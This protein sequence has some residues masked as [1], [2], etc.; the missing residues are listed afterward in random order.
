M[1]RGPSTR[2][3]PAPWVHILI[4]ADTFHTLASH[5]IPAGCIIASRNTAR[6]LDVRTK[7]GVSHRRYAL[8]NDH[9]GMK[10]YWSRCLGSDWTEDTCLP[11]HRVIG[12]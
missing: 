6:P 3:W 8:P 4:W 7:T 2:T 9:P 12:A 1:H 10:D 11:P 5:P